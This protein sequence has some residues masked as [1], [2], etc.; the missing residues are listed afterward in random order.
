MWVRDRAYLRG[1][2]KKKGQ[3]KLQLQEP[4]KCHAGNE[5]V[6]FLSPVDQTLIKVQGNIFPQTKSY[7]FAEGST[8][9]REA[10]ARGM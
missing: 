5:N 9:G 2:L 4:K 8:Q 3:N 1:A 10:S 7:H 6:D